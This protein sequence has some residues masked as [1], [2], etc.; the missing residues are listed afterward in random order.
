MNTDLIWSDVLAWSLQI[1]LLVAIGAAIPALFRIRAPR[2]RLLFW[3][4]LLAACIALPWVREWKQEVVAGAV[5]QVTFLAQAGPATGAPVAP[6]PIPFTAIALWAIAAGI[7][8]RLGN[9]AI[10]L[11]RL[12]T[13]RRRGAALAQEF[14]IP[15]AP[16]HVEIMI[17]ND[18]A[19]PVTFGW[20]EPAILLPARFPS[21]SAAMREAILCHE[22]AHVERR[23]WLSMLAEELLRAV[24]WFH[25]AVWWVIGEIHLA[26][27][28]AVDESVLETTQARE[29]YMDALL[30]M[31]G[32]AP[33]PGADLAPAPMFLRKRHLKKRLVAI[34]KEVRMKR[35]SA[36]RLACATG[37]AM[38]TILAAGWV[39]T[40]MFPLAAAPRYANDGAGVTV[41]TASSR[42]LHR[43]P[44]AYPGEALAKGIEGTVVAQLRLNPD[45]EV[46]DAAILS[47]PQELRKAVLESVLAWH[48]EKSEAASPQTI[49]VTFDKPVPTLA[50]TPPPAAAPPSTSAKIRR[51]VI[52]DLPAEM[53]DSLHSTLPVH[54][55]DDWSPAALA[56]INRTARSF[57]SHLRTSVHRD[58]QGEFDIAIGLPPTMEI[59]SDVMQVGNGVTTPTLISKVEPQYTEQARAA[60]YQGSVLLSTVIGVDG[61]AANLKVVKSLGMGLDESAIKAVQQWRFRPGTKAGLPVKVQAQIE[62]NFRT[63]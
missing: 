2:A 32:V 20:R 57:D 13:Y 23:D 37:A 15:G 19:G 21:L 56:A 60:K 52:N 3:Q 35:V 54:E 24:L 7:A 62:V 55:G 16:R 33:A 43:A 49:S 30:A 18:V 63:L 45:G 47:G 28:Q 42:L 17:S 36:T 39:V 50:Q 11:L 58:R 6:H 61:R 9:L 59:E 12:Q 41:N 53:Q 34:V 40:G 26:R 25:P 1:G 14:R 8:I 51:I 5:R 31:A 22:L 48:F 27:E 46:A 10:G 4:I 29:P 38:M 44:V